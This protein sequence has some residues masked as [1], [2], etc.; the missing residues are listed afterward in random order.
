MT[1]GREGDGPVRGLVAGG[2]GGIGRH[3]V[4]QMVEAGYEVT[5]A[6]LDREGPSRCA[7]ILGPHAP[8]SATS[9]LRKASAKP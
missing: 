1:E 4:A 5:I 6:D 7:P 2:A 9:P 8:G 3:I